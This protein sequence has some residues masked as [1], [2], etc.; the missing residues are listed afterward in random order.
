M[1]PLHRILPSMISLYIF[2]RPRTSFR[3]KCEIID[4]FSSRYSNSTVQVL[5]D[6]IITFPTSCDSPCINQRSIQLSNQFRTLTSTSLQ[7]QP[8]NLTDGQVR[9]IKNGTSLLYSYSLTTQV[10]AN[11][12]GTITNAAPPTLTVIY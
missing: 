11:F 1:F 12:S 3:S 7:I 10:I 2:G 8:S 5:I 4:C 6:F 9:L